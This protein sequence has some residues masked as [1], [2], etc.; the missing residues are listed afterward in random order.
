MAKKKDDKWIQGAIK[1]PG[2]FTK[3][4]EAADKSV[5]EYATDVLKPGSKASTTTKKQANLAK[6]LSKIGKGSGKKK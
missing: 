4:A 2:A 6:V 3:K 5:S 1:H